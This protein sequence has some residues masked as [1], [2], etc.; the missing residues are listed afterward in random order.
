[1]Q[2][3]IDVHQRHR[4]EDIFMEI[5]ILWATHLRN[6]YESALVCVCRYA[7]AA[8]TFDDS[9]KYYEMLRSAFILRSAA[10]QVRPVVPFSISS[11]LRGYSF[12]TYILHP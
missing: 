7:A 6:A 2:R 10:A 9:N 1:M 12:M 8:G 5:T 4:G 11:C 3:I